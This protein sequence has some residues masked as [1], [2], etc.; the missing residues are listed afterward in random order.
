MGT[1]AVKKEG[2]IGYRESLSS[3]FNFDSFD[4]KITDNSRACA[5][6]TFFVFP[7]K[8][9]NFAPYSRQKRLQ[10]GTSVCGLQ[11]LTAYAIC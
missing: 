11:G 9:V 5:V 4:G 6:T 7:S 8:M 10:T 3:T 2:L 1:T